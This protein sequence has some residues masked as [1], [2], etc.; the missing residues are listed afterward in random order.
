[1]KEFVFAGIMGGTGGMRRWF[2]DLLQK[3]GYVVNVWG[4]KSAMNIK[5][6]MDLCNVIV[7]SVPISVTA[8]MIKQVG[9]LLTSDKLLM[10]LT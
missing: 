8:E 4:R 1:M 2:A 6:L 3:E 9:L 5:D 10:D 7:V